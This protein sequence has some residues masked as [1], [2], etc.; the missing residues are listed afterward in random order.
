MDMDVLPFD[1]IS[2]EETV[3]PRNREDRLRAAFEQ[4]KLSYATTE[5]IFTP[6]SVSHLLSYFEW[7]I[8]TGEGLGQ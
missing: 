1:F 2:D 6:P 5:T 3:A 7:Y 4:S 8:L